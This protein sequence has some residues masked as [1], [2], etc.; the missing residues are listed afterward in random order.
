MAGTADAKKR[1]V[2]SPDIVEPGPG[3]FSE[4]IAVGNLFVSSG[5]GSL[6]G[7][8][9]TGDSTFH[10][11]L[12]I[13]ANDAYAQSCNIFEQIK[14]QIEAAGGHIDDIIRLGIYITDMRYRPDVVKARSEYFDNEFMPTAVLTQVAGLAQVEML[15]EM[16]AWGIIGCSGK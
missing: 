2:I 6:K 4:A 16:D 1:R 10:R 9:G 11:D 13:G 8:D 15:V 3:L 7:W 12:I 14:S 5:L